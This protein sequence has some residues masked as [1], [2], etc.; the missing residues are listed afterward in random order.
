MSWM[1]TKLSLFMLAMTFL[2]QQ[3]SAQSLVS[4]SEYRI[5]GGALEPVSSITTVPGSP[6]ILIVKPE[7][8]RVLVSPVSIQ[9]MVIPTDGSSIHWDSFK[10]SY[11]SLRFDITDRFLRLAKRTPSG[12]K[13]DGLEIPAGD[14]RLQM[15]V[16]DNK[17]RWGAREFVLHVSKAVG[18]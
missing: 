9:L 5:Y 8:D 15:S 16:R 14:H 11:G 12:F 4:E 6:E 13:I 17:S 3:A 18:P 2:L 7:L 10:L 1:C